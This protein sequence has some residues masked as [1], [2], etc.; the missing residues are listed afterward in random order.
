MI[1]IKLKQSMIPDFCFKTRNFQIC[2]KTSLAY[3]VV[4]MLQLLVGTAL[5]TSMQELHVQPVAIFARLSEKNLRL[6]L[7]LVIPL[8]VLKFSG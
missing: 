4:G 2:V 7:I 6:C 5:K 8:T 3:H 1:Y